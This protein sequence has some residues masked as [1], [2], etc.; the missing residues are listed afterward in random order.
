MLLCTIHLPASHHH[1]YGHMGSPSGTRTSVSINC[2]SL[3]LP[4]HPPPPPQT[5][6]LDKNVSAKS[7]ST[8]MYAPKE[9]RNKRKERKRKKGFFQICL[10]NGKLILSAMCFLFTAIEW[11]L[12]SQGARA[13]DVRKNR[14]SV[15]VFYA[16]STFDFVNARSANP[17]HCQTHT[18]S[19]NNYII[20]HGYKGWEEGGWGGKLKHECGDM[21]GGGG[22][23]K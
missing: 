23:S 15:V 10:V 3:V 5:P 12:I 13:T 7:V 6:C 20:T 1:H 19:G 22:P 21:E 11:R 16:C 14:C 8:K 4:L 2:S 9:K 17:K 18:A